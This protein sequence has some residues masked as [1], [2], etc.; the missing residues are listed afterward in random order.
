MPWYFWIF[1]SKA[2]INLAIWGWWCRCWQ[3][4]I[5]QRPL[6]SLSIVLNSFRAT[7][8]RRRYSL[9]V[10]EDRL[11]MNCWQQRLIAKNMDE[12]NHSVARSM[13][14]MTVFPCVISLI[15]SLKQSALY[16]LLSSFVVDC[17]LAWTLTLNL[18]LK[19]I[20]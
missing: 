12:E 11:Y 15:I 3:A 8:W 5:D 20:R 9:G 7:V 2:K 14:S 16:C 1:S 6:V 19:D 13:S 17:C 4:C 18:A 10:M